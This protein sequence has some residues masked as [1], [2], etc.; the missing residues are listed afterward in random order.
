MQVNE[1]LEYN[2]GSQLGGCENNPTD[3]MMIMGSEH[4]HKSEIE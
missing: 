1:G 2:Q 3:M 4:C